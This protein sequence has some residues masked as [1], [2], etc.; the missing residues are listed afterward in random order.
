MSNKVL[1][2]LLVE[3]SHV[4][5]F[6]IKKV[7]QKNMPYKCK[8]EHIDDMK[9]AENFLQENSVDII[10][11]DLGL[12]DTRGGKDTFNRAYIS[13]SE[14]PIIILTSKEDHDLAVSLVD[15]GAEDYVRKSNI[16]SDPER[17]CDAIDF[18]VCRHKNST[19]IKNQ[20]NEAV[21]EKDMM[22]EWVRGGYSV[23]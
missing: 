1:K 13:Q 18:A 6:M 5:A 11:L 20:K 23:K 19:A 8:I 22:L 16:T 9:N 17:I 7:L 3:D 4:D 21:I 12:P 2:L 14:T 15:E 10:L